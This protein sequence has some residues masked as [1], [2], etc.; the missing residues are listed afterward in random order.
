MFHWFLIALAAAVGVNGLLSAYEVWLN[1]FATKYIW[2][3]GGM[4]VVGIAAAVAGL[5]EAIA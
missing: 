4:G 5:V 2:R 3:D 1:D